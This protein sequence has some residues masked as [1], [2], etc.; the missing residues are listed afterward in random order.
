MQ[1][2]DYE[3]DGIARGFKNKFI[4]DDNVFQRAKKPVTMT[5]DADVSNLARQSGALDLTDATIQD[6][7][8]G[9]GEDG[10]FDPEPGNPQQ[11]EGRIHLGQEALLI[12]LDTSLGPQGRIDRIWGGR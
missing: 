6:Q 7:I 5:G 8:T 10:R 12:L 9:A 3:C 1:F 11:S 4:A 2:L